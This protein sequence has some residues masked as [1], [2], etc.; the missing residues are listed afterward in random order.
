[1]AITLTNL[2]SKIRNLVG[3]GAIAGIDLFEY[4]TSSVF[5]LTESNVNSITIVY[6]NEVE[7]GDSEYSYDSDL[8]KLTVNASMDSGDNVNIEYNYYSNYS[9]TEIQ[10]YVKAAV[11]H[12]SANNYTT[13]VVR[14]SNVY[15]E[16]NE[17]DQNLISMV[18]ALLIK[19]D[20]KTYRLPDVSVIVPKDLPLHDK[21]RKTIVIFKRDPYGV[22]F[23]A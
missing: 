1:M 9:S 21:I 2:E 8:N 15:P 19:P 12:I 3:D 7:I 20:N 6:V 5:T 10:N 23:I 16:P 11:I 18:A 22:I 4:T 14:S 17:R 13:W